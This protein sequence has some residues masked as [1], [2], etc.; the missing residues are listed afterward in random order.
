MLGNEQ[1]IYIEGAPAELSRLPIPAG[2]LVVGLD[3][4]IVR[5]RRGTNGDLDRAPTM[6]ATQIDAVLAAYGSP[7]AGQ[8]RTFYDLGVRSGI[9]PAWALAFFVVESQ[10]GTRGVARVTR[11]I[12]NIRCTAGYACVAGYRAY[13]SWADS[14]TDWYMLMRTLYLDTWGRP[15]WPRSR[16]RLVVPSAPPRARH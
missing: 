16:P 10:A 1:T 6:S 5:A 13:V 9:D 11:G 2:P 14:I 15:A 4:G 3:G 7:A 12:G 8:G